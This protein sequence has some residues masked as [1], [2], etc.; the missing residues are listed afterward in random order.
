MIDITNK[1]NTLRIAKASATVIVGSADTIEAVKNKKVPKGDIFEMGKAAALLAI[2]NTSNV[3]PDCHPMPIEFAAVSYKMEGLKIEIEVEVKTIYKTGVEVEAMYGA[4]VAAITIY[5]ML[6][7]LDKQIEISAIKLIEKKGGKSDFITDAKKELSAAIIVCSDSISKGE[8][9][10]R[11]GK[12]IIEKLEKFNV[13]I[14]E[15]IVIPDEADV[16]RE[17]VEKLASKSNM[18]ILTGGTGL[19]PRDVTPEALR[20]ILHREIPGIA[21]A[22]R[23]YGQAHTPYSMLSR[24][25]AGLI[26]ETL[27]LALPGS[28]KGAKESIDAIFPFVLHIF[29]VMKALRH[30]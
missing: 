29:R 10:D 23:N 7:P 17:T 26:N 2:K 16:I 18:V 20:P 24:S 11:A 4:S 15:Y 3:V 19:S 9:E 14:S 12:A 22:I 21:E 25:I 5:D 13:L 28:T 27:I 8:K 1:V 30:D 6:K